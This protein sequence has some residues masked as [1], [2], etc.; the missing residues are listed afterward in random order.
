MQ[1]YQPLYQSAFVYRN[2][3]MFDLRPLQMFYQ[4]AEYEGKLVAR[5]MPITDQAVLIELRAI[6]RKMYPT[7]GE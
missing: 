2:G 5:F 6:R 3:K 7:E 1:V 4:P